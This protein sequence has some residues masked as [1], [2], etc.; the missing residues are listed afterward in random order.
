MEPGSAG[1]EIANSAAEVAFAQLDGLWKRY[2]D[3][4]NDAMLVVPGTYRGEQLGAACSAS[5]RKPASKFARSSIRLRPRACGRTRITSCCM[6]T[7]ALYRLAATL[8]RAER[9]RTRAVRAEDSLIT[10]GLASLTE[11]FARRIADL[12][13]RATRFDPLHRAETEQALYDKLPAW[14]EQLREQ[15]RIEASSSTTTRS[16]KRVLEREAVLGVAAGFYRARRAADR[17]S[18]ASAARTSS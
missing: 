18:P 8:R 13:V 9:R 3:G 6:S 14:L 10:T 15:E 1:S 4:A 11:A 16:S 5:R 2:G 12:F 17:V 7:R